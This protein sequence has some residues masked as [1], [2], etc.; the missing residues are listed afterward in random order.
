[1]MRPDAPTHAT[2]QIIGGQPQSP[3][4]WPATLILKGVAGLCTATLVGP[5]AIITAAHCIAPQD[6]GLILIDDQPIAAHCWRHE[7]YESS[8]E[9]Y[10]LALCQAGADVPLIGPH[11]DY[12]RIS[13]DTPPQAAGSAVY[14]LGAGCHNAPPPGQDPP[15]AGPPYVLY[16]APTK[17]VDSSP[18]D[19]TLTKDGGA[20]CNG[21]SGG[22]AYVRDGGLHRK[23][24][25]IV[26]RGN[27]SD[28]SFITPFHFSR[29]KLFLDRSQLAICTNLTSGPC[30]D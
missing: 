3:Q 21:D 19:F 6:S 25:G 30:H 15:P 17:V 23:I 27:R 12:E 8:G 26:S 14:L 9:K 7:D 5:R 10:D 11:S 16:G 22:A 24:V 28:I 1:M 29:M 18:D 20:S 13:L 4:D 2:P